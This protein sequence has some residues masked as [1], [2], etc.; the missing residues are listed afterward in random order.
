VGRQKIAVSKKHLAAA[1]KKV[2]MGAS[3]TSV[4]SM[5]GFAAGAYNSDYASEDSRITGPVAKSRA[6]EFGLKW[7]TKPKPGRPVEK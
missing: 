4:N 3:H 6:I 1:I 5:F 7:K 2:E